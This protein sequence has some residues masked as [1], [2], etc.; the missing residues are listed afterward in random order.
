MYPVDT[1]SL[2]LPQLPTTST[3]KRGKPNK[4]SHTPFTLLVNG[5]KDGKIGFCSTSI[6]VLNWS[7][8]CSLSNFNNS[9]HLPNKDRVLMKV[10]MM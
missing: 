7:Q 1:L 5:N 8:K 6:K 4:K 3:L 2:I 10:L 9:T